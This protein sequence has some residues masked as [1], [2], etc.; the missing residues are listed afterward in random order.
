VQ[1][2]ENL[3]FLT[4]DPVG[5]H[6]WRARHHQLARARHSARTPTLR[7]LAQSL[8]GLAYAPG[9]R[10]GRLWPIQGDKGLRFV[11]VGDGLPGVPDDHR[12]RA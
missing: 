2:G 1:H 11:E 12:Q 5:N 10:R 9:R 4:A 6:E 7:E 3:D 8:D